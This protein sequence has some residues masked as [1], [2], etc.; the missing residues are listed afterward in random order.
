M[1]ES[2]EFRNA[3][4]VNNPEFWFK[5]YVNLANAFVGNHE[6]GQRQLASGRVQNDTNLARIDGIG[7]WN[8]ATPPT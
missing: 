4:T 7:S 8:P 5:D 2:V 1:V 6:R 3:V